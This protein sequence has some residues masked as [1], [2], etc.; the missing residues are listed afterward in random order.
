MLFTCLSEILLN[1]WEHAV[2]DNRSIIIA[3]GTKKKIEIA[4]ADTGEGIITSLKTNP[5]YSNMH[6]SKI[7][8]KALDIGATSKERTNHMGYGLWIINEITNLVRGKLYIYSEGYFFKND[9]GKVK[10]GSCAFWKGTIVYLNLPL[11]NPV[12]FSDL[13]SKVKSFKRL[14]D[15]KINFI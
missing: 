12:S 15:I 13:E 2:D 1:F 8:S 4:C 9:H 7:L 3:D 14:T 10:S 11:G 6:D 5:K